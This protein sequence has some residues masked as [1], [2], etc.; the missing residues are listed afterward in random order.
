MKQSNNT[1]QKIY[2]GYA[3]FYVSQYN[4]NITYKPL[5]GNYQLI[6][7]NPYVWILKSIITRQ[8]LRISYDCDDILKQLAKSIERRQIPLCR[9]CR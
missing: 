7:F 1:Q 6:T 8:L 9:I 2:I 3:F 5:S 4:Q